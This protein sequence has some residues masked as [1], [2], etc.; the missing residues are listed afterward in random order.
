MLL[1]GDRVIDGAGL[2]QALPFHGAV[3]GHTGSIVIEKG[4]DCTLPPGP[5]AV[6][7]HVVRPCILL[8]VE[9]LLDPPVAGEKLVDSKELAPLPEQLTEID[10]A[11]DA[12][13]LIV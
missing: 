7:L 10:V 2:T 8:L 1:V 3:D 13:Q 11:L 12:V 6:S 4:A 9:P 5:F